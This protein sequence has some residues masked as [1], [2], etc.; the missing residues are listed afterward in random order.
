MHAIHVKE[1]GKDF[2]IEFAAPGCYKKDFEVSI[3]NKVL[4]RCG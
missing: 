1:H 2:E 4:N 3:D